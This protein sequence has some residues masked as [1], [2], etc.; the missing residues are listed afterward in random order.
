[1]LQHIRLVTVKLWKQT[2]ILHQYFGRF[3]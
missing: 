2:K 3:Q 1:M